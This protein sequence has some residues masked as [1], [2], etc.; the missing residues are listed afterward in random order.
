MNLNI[1]L[2]SI[3]YIMVF[4]FP[5]VLF[6][7]FYFLDN[8]KN[9]YAQGNLFERFI[10]A[11]TFSIISIILSIGIILFFRKIVGIDFL[12]SVSLDT[13]R[14][15]FEHIKKNEI[16]RDIKKN[17]IGFF[18]LISLIYAI[19]SFLGFALRHLVVKLRLDISISWLRYNHIWNYV[20]EGKI[21]DDIKN[22]KHLYTNIDLLINDGYKKVMY[23]GVLLDIFV[24][25]DEKIDY[26]L[27]EKCF[28]YK[29]H[30]KKKIEGTEEIKGNKEKPSYEK[31]YIKGNLMCFKKE[32]IIN[33]NLEHIT[34]EKDYKIFK[35]IVIWILTILFLAGLLFVVISPWIKEM[36]FEINGILRKIVFIIFSVSLLSFVYGFILDEIKD[37][38]VESEDAENEGPIINDWISFFFF[39]LFLLIPILWAINVYKWW[40]IFILWGIAFIS[41]LLTVLIYV[42]FRKN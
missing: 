10:L 25:K 22:N 15:T 33:F 36:F 31:Q 26:I 24:D 30:D 39:F 3:F 28:K 1:G 14:N 29:F 40:M 20:S 23:S 18:I 2:S 19:S 42:R 7:K 5:G 13:V 37:E 8:S 9:H 35:N 34:R 12:S 6:R 17:A 32:N 11:I 41:L 4:I 21:I 16:P 38:G 27:V